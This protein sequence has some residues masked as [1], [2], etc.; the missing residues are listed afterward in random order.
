MTIPRTADDLTSE[1]C[2]DALGRTITTVT[3]TPLGVGMGLIG[4]LHRLELDGPDGPSTVIAKMA[5]PTDEGR[6]VATVSTCTGARPAS[7]AALTTHDNCAP[8]LLSLRTRS[9]DP[10]RGAPPRRRVAAWPAPG[11]DRGCSVAE[12][13]PAIGASRSLHTC[14]WDDATLDDADLL[15]KLADDP[16]P[17]AVAFAYDTAWPRVAGVLPRGR[18]PASAGVRRCVLPRRSPRCSR[19][20]SS[21]RSCWPTATGDSTISSSLPTVT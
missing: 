6:F 17:A 19:S 12:A 21:R 8:G 11:S 9:G 10:R 16:Y 5:A 18:Q 1:W 7:T 13:R 3:P 14:F 20:W 2:S 15:L 4:Q